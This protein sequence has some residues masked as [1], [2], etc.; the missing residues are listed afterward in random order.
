MLNLCLKNLHSC[1]TIAETVDIF[2]TANDIILNFASGK[3]KVN[4]F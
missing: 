3:I 1:D 2:L 4:R